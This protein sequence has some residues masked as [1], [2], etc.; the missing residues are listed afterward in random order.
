MNVQE[1]YWPVYTSNHLASGAPLY[2]MYWRNLPRL[3]KLGEYWYGRRLAI[4]SGEHGP[5]GEPFPGYFT[6]EHSPGLGAWIAH[7][8]W[9]HWLYSRD[10]RFLRE[11]AYPFLREF[12]QAYLHIIE[13]RA[14]G[15]YHIPFTD[16]PE[17]YEGDP[18]SMGDDTTFDLMLL[19]FL[20]GALLE[21]Q[22]ELPVPDP[23]R[24]RWREVLE[25]LVEPSL[26]NGGLALRPNEPLAHSHRHHSHL[27]GI[28]P[29]GVLDAERSPAER[30]VIE[31]SLKELI[32][33]GTGE[34]TGWSYPWAS[35]IAGRAGQ[36]EM[37][38]QYLQTYLDVF[39]APNSLHVN[40]DYRRKGFSVHTYQA[41]TLEAGFAYAAAIL[42]MLLQS[43]HGLIR[44]FP[45][46]PSHWGDVQFVN[47]R[48]EGAFL[49]SARR[50]DHR[51]RFV[52]IVS[53]AGG[54]CR[55]RNPFGAECVMVGAA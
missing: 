23:D 40:G 22:A 31:A 35:M 30:D 52:E 46:C 6:D 55:V 34:W 10:R 19:R 27:L 38:H 36:A 2:R 47:L 3:R 16:T 49:V 32:L 42:E 33:K 12:V 51:V 21:T 9:L 44:L 45:T 13:K 53:E 43:H 39:I 37:A 15:K 11:R 41:M 24:M 18:R 4:I 50:Q 28:F 20:L 5:G 29:L 8:F 1:S 25:L 26:V 7:H 48:A 17:Y 14:D 54:P